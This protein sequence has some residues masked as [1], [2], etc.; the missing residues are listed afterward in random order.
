MGWA[1]QIN[2]K[3]VPRMEFFPTMSLRH[4]GPK[5]GWGTELWSGWKTIH[6]KYLLLSEI[7]SKALRMPKRFAEQEKQMIS[8]WKCIRNSLWTDL[9]NPFVLFQ[10]LA[11]AAVLHF[12]SL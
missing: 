12:F 7:R 1:K 2:N 8:A 9:W 4:L 3:I 5:Q 10:C 11:G 6:S